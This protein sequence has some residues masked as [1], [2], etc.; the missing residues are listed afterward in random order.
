MAIV[1]QASGEKWVAYL[2]DTVE[3]ARELPDESVDLSV[4]SPPFAS[5]FTYSAHE[6]DMGNVR[7]YEEFFEHYAYLTREQARVLKPGRLVA[8][9]CMLLPTSKSKDGFIGLRDF[10]GDLIR[11]YQAAGFVFHSEVVIWKDPVTAM[12]RT[13]ALGLLHKQIKK[14]SCMSRQGIPD[15]VVVMRKPGENPSPVT[16]D[17]STFPVERWQ[18]W[19]SPV[20]VTTQG[21]DE[22]GFA[23]CRNPKL[24]DQTEG[25]GIYQGDTL[26]ARAAREQEDERHLCPLQ[27][28]VVRRVVRL[29]SNPGDV[30]WTPFGGVGTEA[31]VAVEEGRLAIL[32]ELKASYWRQAVANLRAAEAAPTRHE[33]IR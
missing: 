18:R 19:A 25:H 20:W 21:V 24:E 32:A 7:S 26:N 14:D 9:H 5:L 13:K 27:R 1:D 29:W 30:V 10:R 23:V 3:V 16:H 6:R 4:F 2:G 8:V 15:Y 22:E 11:A 31:V 17:D 33:V 28:D 12:Q